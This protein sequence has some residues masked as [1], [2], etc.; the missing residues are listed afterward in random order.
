EE[1]ALRGGV[2]ERQAV[3]QRGQHAHVVGGHAVHAA[4]AAGEA[5]KDVAAA[6]D[7]ADLDAERVHVAHFLGQLR[8]HVLVDAVAGLAGEQLAGELE[9]DAL[10]P[11]LQPTYS[12]PRRKRTKRRTTVFS[13]ALDG[14]LLTS[15][16]T[17]ILSSLMN[18][19]SIRHTSP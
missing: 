14:V 5:A 2:R 1:V 3:D 4:R 16:P 15:S 13:P 17:T 10:R 19:C 12:A 9:Q 8:Q 7:D 18:A 11:G 6:E